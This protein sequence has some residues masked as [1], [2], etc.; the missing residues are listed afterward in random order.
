[1]CIR[2]SSCEVAQK[3]D[4]LKGGKNIKDG[5]YI[6]SLYFNGIAASIARQWKKSKKNFVNGFSIF[7]KV[8]SDCSN[9]PHETINIAVSVDV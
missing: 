6:I 5:I 9:N 7:E 4:V 8:S 3:S 2:D 1:M